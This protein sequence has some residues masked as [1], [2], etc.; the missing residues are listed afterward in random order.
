MKPIRIVMSAF[1]PYADKTE[2]SFDRFDGRG[3][4]L[5]TGDTGAGKTTIFDGITFALYGEASGSA[6]ES[7][8]L[9]SDFATPYVK[10][11][12]ELTFLHRNRIYK[13]FRSPKYLRPKKSGS[14][15]T[16]EN[17]EAVI[18][19]PDGA[20]ISGTR[21]VNQTVE[22]LLGLTVQQFK[23][24]VMIA[25]GEFRRLLLS[26]SAERVDIF[27]KIF[28]TGIF[29]DIQE[30]LKTM[31]RDAK[32]DCEEKTRSIAQSAEG[33]QF[34]DPEYKLFTTEQIHQIPGLLSDLRKLI[35]EDEK[36]LRNQI[37]RSE[38]LNIQIIDQIKSAAEGEYLQ[39]S[40]AE[41]EA[42]REFQKD[43]E[44]RK[45]EYQETKTLLIAAEKAFRIVFPAEEK[46]R[47]ALIQQ[48]GLEEKI[49]NLSSD[50][51]VLEE[52]HNRL[53]NVYIEERENIPKHQALMSETDSLEKSFSR[54]DA[55]EI[56]EKQ[57]GELSQHDKTIQFEIEKSSAEKNELDLEKKA[58]E[59]VLEEFSLLKVQNVQFE[60]EKNFRKQ[61]ISRLSAL[62][63]AVEKLENC[64]REL[65]VLRD[66]YEVK[67]K[68]F[69]AVNRKYTDSEITFL[70]EQAGILASRLNDNEPC[71]VCGSTEHP[72]KTILTE[73][74][75]DEAL[76][77]SLRLSVD[78][79]RKTL[80]QTGTI[81]KSK[82]VEFDTERRHIEK[83]I[84][85]YN[86]EILKRDDL[87]PDNNQID[88][89]N[90]FTAGKRVHSDETNQPKIGTE[91][92][93]QK[94][95]TIFRK[96]LDAAVMEIE[97]ERKSEIQAEIVMK[98]KLEKQKNSELRLDELTK[99][100]QENEEFSEKKR[101]QHSKV[102][103]DLATTR[104][105][106]KALRDSLPA[107]TKQQIIKQ[108]DE[109]KNEV[110]SLKVALEKA[111]T[112]FRESENKL[113][114]DRSLFENLNTEIL[115]VKQETENTYTTYQKAYCE[116]GF[117]EEQSYLH[118]LKPEEEIVKLRDFCSVYEEKI[119]TAE[120]DFQRLIKI[121][122]G[123]TCPDMTALS[124]A[125][126]EAEEM[127]KNLEQEMQVFRNR[128]TV[129]IPAEKTI[130]KN[131]KEL[132]I[133][134]EKY[135]MISKLAR[136][137]AG[138]ISGKQKRSFESYVQTFYFQQ[139]L[140]EANK[141]LTKMTD[142]RFTLLHREE[143]ASLRSQSGLEIDVM[144]QYTGKQRPVKSLSGGESFK[145][146]LALALGLSDVVQSHAGGV[147]MDTLFVD[148]GF[149]S[150]DEESMEQAIQTLAGLAEGSRLVGII[151]H[152][153]ELKERIDRQIIVRRHH[154]GS[155]IT[156]KV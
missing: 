21:E 98:K 131:W 38:K 150:L 140:R 73:S 115:S 147:E 152:V 2:L 127:K 151:S 71:P 109:M 13:I 11:F 35:A 10:T 132:R 58:T 122:E 97:K 42:N 51:H 138:D 133:L 1:G 49:Q 33:I 123:Q 6:R 135:L 85:D 105:E 34:P 88:L 8:I 106:A 121:T 128:L 130:D 14:G 3:L 91:D 19:M 146:S 149:G 29:L 36:I 86:E 64:K 96:F 141:R 63:S 124:Q 17:A 50:I 72:K 100:L 15:M 108:Y 53:T 9:R 154:K 110:A 65:H 59:S 137:I 78:E 5:I 27:R 143:A 92:S 107:G 20:V 81:Y 30:M 39:K 116:A 23:Q 44:S 74:A 145:A 61:R 56:L 52:K 16:T 45:V 103:A 134:R 89:P 80:E 120:Q 119:R 12:A 102:T 144:D 84:R 18:W 76:L 87:Y 83:D 95:L 22:D 155:T 79:S 142:G 114:G 77:Q 125:R 25:Q 4:F 70:R 104:G 31:E 43:L 129:N 57:I 66:A 148:E 153:T 93:D 47:R 62:Q 112:D 24:I 118:A 75:P 28:Q 69:N 54:Y 117:I 48:K 90:D 55:L 94:D 126:A 156:T 7:D 40:F 68:D 41:L 37:N 82:K 67:E 113:S 26:G 101:I 139:I 46:W 111:E 60:N 32:N 136:T 99:M